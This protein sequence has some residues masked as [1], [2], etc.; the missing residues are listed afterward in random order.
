[1]T[2][3]SREFVEGALS[4]RGVAL[5]ASVPEDL[6]EISTDTRTI[7]GERFFLALV[8]ERF[9]AHDFV[10]D[11][12][13]AG[14]RA[15]VAARDRVPAAAD[16]SRLILVDDTL[17]ALQ[18]LAA[19]HLDALTARRVA[20]TGS[21]GKTSTKELAAAC[22]RACLGD[23]AVLATAGNL[24]NHVGLPLT[25]L[26]LE[27]QHRAAVFEMG[28]NH[29]GEIARLC[30]IARPEAGLITNI[31][32]AHA[33]NLGGV[34]GVARAKGELFEA[35][36]SSGTGVVNLDDARCV[37]EAKAR[38]TARALTFGRDPG[39]DL[40]IIAVENAEPSGLRVTLAFAGR[41]VTARV[42]L[43]GE[44]NALNAAG[45]VGLALALGL[46]FERAARGLEGARGVEGRLLR[47]VAAAGA[48]V[49]DDTYNANPDSMRA[50][51]AAL[52]ALAGG[53]RRVAALGQM[54]ELDD[55]KAAHREVGRAAVERGVERL[56]ACG[57][58]GRGYG[59]GAAEAGLAPERFTW[60]KDS[61]ALA[62]LV[63][64]ELGP[65][66]AVLVKGSR[67]ARMENVVDRLVRGE[68]R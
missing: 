14:A 68:V 19:A 30:E 34:E 5:G 41:E 48:L 15:V 67:G 54:L 61:A 28:M 9:D 63:A 7:T 4:S 29:L 65:G 2:T 35:L 27:T 18:D 47:K 10:A 59:E 36:P 11:A 20:L 45:A 66:D 40:R 58:L 13:A 26:R 62:D 55:P 64:R 43:D 42:P 17:L 1:M 56:F 39:A 44:H 22:L 53:R 32:T 8:G 51:L 3:L 21:N 31:G 50:G 6:G 37:L 33:G 23:D 12:L 60:A 46:D 57:D 24:N 25:A 52:A 38:L 16:R 49:L